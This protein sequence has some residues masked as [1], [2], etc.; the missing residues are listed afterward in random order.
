MDQVFDVAIIGGGINGCGC[1]ADAALRGLSVVLLEQ[2]D[3]ASKTSSKSTGL[4]HG[5]LRY[6]EQLDFSLV[7]KAL[8]ERQILL[9][10]APHLVSP[11]PFVLPYQSSTRPFWLIRLGLFL[12]D[13]LSSKNKLP[14]S[15]TLTR[16]H[17]LFYFD[18]LN[19]HISKGLM[20]YDCATDDARLTIENA[21]LAQLHGA[22]I[23]T[24]TSVLE[25]IVQNNIWHLKLSS[26]DEKLEYIRAKAVINTAGPWVNKI[27]QQ[28]HINDKHTVTLV[29]GSH[30]VV[31][32]LYKGQHAYLLQHKDK[33]IIFTIPYHGLT[34]IG[35]TDVAYNGS[36]KHL[37]ISGAE[38]D[39]LLSITQSYFKTSV[40]KSQI[41][42]SWSGVRPLVTS[43]G[44]N[45][46]TLSRDYQI[47]FSNIEAPVVSVFG[48]KITTYR[49]LAVDT[50]D[51]L[52]EVFKDL[53]PSCTAS[54]P[55]PGAMFGELDFVK[56]QTFARQKYGWLDTAVL[57]HYLHRYG[58]RSEHLLNGHNSMSS[59]GIQFSPIL[60]QAEI[61]FLVETE[62]AQNA[63]DILWRRTKFGLS[64]DNAMKS[65][66]ENYLL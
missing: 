41:I 49:H 54:T 61:D 65:A 44:K 66:L 62:W 33:R 7:K 5:G 51:K 3:L 38:I 34:L 12:Y 50:I 53:P 47:D 35:T 15:S 37:S 22:N 17:D 31:P 32:K 27:N 30:L 14:H 55:L 10:I 28:L 57:E 58:T 48:G 1:A 29:K 59:L 60:F 19:D 26:K 40:D 9:Q 36:L 52:R 16:A 20:Y 23:L 6:L 46:T 42:T 56:Y 39:Y 64:I 63:D 43:I 2:D 8:N 13:H 21:L 11:L 24:H 25:G 18:S 4:I 45:P